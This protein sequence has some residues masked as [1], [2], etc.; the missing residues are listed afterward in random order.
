MRKVSDALPTS[1]RTSRVADFIDHRLEEIHKESGKSIGQI[2]DEAGLPQR[3]MLSMIRKGVTKLPFDRV[4]G[5]AQSLEVDVIELLWLALD[6]YQPQL[7][8]LLKEAQDAILTRDEE[9]IVEFWRL[10]TENRNP[11][12]E[13]IQEELKALFGR[14]YARSILEDRG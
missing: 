6:E 4:R 13:P 12:V 2:A 5:I 3:N 8:E 11:A 14:L 1:Q 10:A 9:K 7:A